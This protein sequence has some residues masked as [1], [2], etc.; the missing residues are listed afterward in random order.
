MRFRG[1]LVSEKLKW[2]ITLEN[3]YIN[4]QA[5]NIPKS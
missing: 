1:S 5:G 4:V 3:Q 2:L